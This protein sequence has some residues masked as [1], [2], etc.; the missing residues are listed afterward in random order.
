M[1][2]YRHY[3]SEVKKWNKY[4]DK[5]SGRMNISFSEGFIDQ[6]LDTDKLMHVL[7]DNDYSLRVQ[8]FVWQSQRLVNPKLTFKAFQ[9]KMAR[10]EVKGEGKEAKRLNVWSNVT[11]TA[12]RDRMAKSIRK[13]VGVLQGRVN[14]LREPIDPLKVKGRFYRLDDLASRVDGKFKSKLIKNRLK[15]FKKNYQDYTPTRLE[16]EY[17]KITKLLEK[18]II[19]NQQK[20]VMNNAVQKSA[21]SPAK[22]TAQTTLSE[23]A[24]LQVLGEAETDGDKYLRY[25]L[26]P[27]RKWKGHDICDKFAGANP[28]GLGKGVYKISDV[29]VPVRSTHPNCGCELVKYNDDK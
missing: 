14:W 8:K 27:N 9:L 1:K 3:L 5:L 25:I 11:N 19:D 28:E 21:S 13:E 4:V 17:K 22:R 15:K 26:N 23:E 6:T 18:D 16:K 20:E 29:P 2:N 10:A 24:N 7:R 12:T